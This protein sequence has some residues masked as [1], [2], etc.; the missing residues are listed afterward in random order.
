MTERR[1]KDYPLQ[2][3]FAEKQG[4]EDALASWKWM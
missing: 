4:T 1:Y 2:R 3:L